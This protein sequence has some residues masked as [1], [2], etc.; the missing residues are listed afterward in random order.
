M[1]D[2]AVETTVE[3]SD[4]RYVAHLSRNWE[5]W[6]PNGGYLAVNALR[7]AARATPFDRPASFVCHFLRVARFDD[8]QLSVTTL[9]ASRRASSVRVVMTQGSDQILEALVWMVADGEGLEHDVARP[10][11]VPRPEALRP[12]E[13]LRSPAEQAVVYP[14]WQNLESRPVEWLDPSEWRPRPPLFQSWYRFRPTAVFDD[15]VVDAGR[16]LLLIDTMGWPAAWRLHGNGSGWVA[17]SLDVSVRFHRAAPAS[18][19]LL[20]E[21]TAPVATDGLVGGQATIWS[22]DGQL[23]ASGGGQLLCRPTP[24]G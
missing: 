7:A 16:A 13:E 6:G 12:T 10:P 21:A 2:L 11:D 5:I 1:G 20:C 3:G 4:G 15:P 14:F 24:A 9:R 18:E 22:A 17:P 23:L 19:W 8:V